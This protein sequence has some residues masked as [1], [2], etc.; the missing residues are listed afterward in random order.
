[1]GSKG[2]KVIAGQWLPKC[3]FVSRVTDGVLAQLME[4]A[5]VAK[6][7]DELVTLLCED[8]KWLVDIPIDVW[9][10]VAAAI[11][12]SGEDLRASC[13]EGGH[14]AFHFFWRRVFAPSDGPPWRLCRDDVWENLE[15]LASGQQPEEP[16]SAQLWRLM[17]LKFSK[18]QLLAALELMSDIS[19]SSMS[20]EQQ[21][22]SM[23]VLQ[24]GSMVCKH[25]SAAL[26]LCKCAASSLR[27]P[28]MSSSWQPCSDSCRKF[29]PGTLTRLQ[30]G[31]HWCPSS[32]SICALARVATQLDMS[33]QILPIALSKAAPGYGSSVV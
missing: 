23:A 26:W 19:W 21:H 28:R 29:S 2:C 5:R 13:I 20:V 22:G 3:A 11:P 15:E 16:V 25:W 8:M 18:T 9:D 17:H 10:E 14:I 27:Y 24:H 1:M 32:S 4:D 7:H 30:V 31:K 6:H 12:E 33:H